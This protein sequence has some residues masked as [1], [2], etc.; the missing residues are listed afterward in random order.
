MGVDADVVTFGAWGPWPKVLFP[1]LGEHSGVDQLLGDPADQNSPAGLVG[2]VGTSH[3]EGDS[4]SSTAA[5]SFA[6][7]PAR[8][9][10]EPSCIT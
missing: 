4:G 2:L 1:E 9:T 5:A 3:F 10:T 6:P 7:G 8:K